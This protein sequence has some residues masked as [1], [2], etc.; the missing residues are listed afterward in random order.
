MDSGQHGSKSKVIEMSR[1][2]LYMLCRESAARKWED[3]TSYMEKKLQEMMKCPEGEFQT[4]SNDLKYF[5]C[6][7]QALSSISTRLCKK[8][9]TGSDVLNRL[10]LTSD[11]FLSCQR[12]RQRSKSQ[13][14]LSETIRLFESQEPEVHVDTET[15]LPEHSAESE[16][17][18]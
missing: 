5:I 16:E 2:T 1:K 15:G 13:P 12:K 3:K 18:L 11:Q 17:A 9:F 6:S 4:L 14:F 7:K 8:I 10:L